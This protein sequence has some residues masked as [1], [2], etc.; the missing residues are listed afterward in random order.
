MYKPDNTPAVFL[1]TL[2]LSHP[3]MTE[4][5]MVGTIIETLETAK[6]KGDFTSI[7]FTSEKKDDT[8][9]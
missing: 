4:T 5:R 8:S 3:I 7:F 6:I 1:E 2:Y 9:F